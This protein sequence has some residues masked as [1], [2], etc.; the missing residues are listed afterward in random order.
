M[1]IS[2]GIVAPGEM[3]CFIAR[4][5]VAHGVVALT[6]VEGRS[7]ASKARAQDGGFDIVPSDADLVARS[8]L[9]LSVVPP[10]AA[11]SLAE[12]FAPVIARSANKPVYVDCNAIAPATVQRITDILAKTGSAYVDGCLF[13]GPTSGKPGVVLYVSGSAAAQVQPLAQHGL[14]VRR[15]TGDIGAASALKLAFAGLNKGF[16]ALGACMVMAAQRAGAAEGLAEQLLDSQPAIMAYLGRFVPAMFPK[17]GRWAPEM[18]EVAAFLGD[19]PH[20]AAI[21]DA[22]APLYEQIAAAV[23]AESAEIAALRAFCVGAAASREP[24]T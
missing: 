15:L 11:V 3:G 5:L 22:M 13:G 18:K 19:D 16:T 12:R 14:A 20:A 9:L 10:D 24:R 7:A 8:Q 2:V 23:S 17:A 6:S 21:F 4:T 1:S